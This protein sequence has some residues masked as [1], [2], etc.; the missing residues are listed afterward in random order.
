[1]VEGM[2]RLTLS[3]FSSLL[4]VERSRRWAIK[5]VSPRLLLLLASKGYQ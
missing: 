5:A 4:L 1:M 3:W 2:P